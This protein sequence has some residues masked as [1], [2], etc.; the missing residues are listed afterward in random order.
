MEDKYHCTVNKMKLHTRYIIFLDTTNQEMKMLI[1]GYILSNAC[2]CE[3]VKNKH[4]DIWNLKYICS[5]VLL[6]PAF[7]LNYMYYLI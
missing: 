3:N 5:V 7:V 2:I 1:F 6:V 4:T